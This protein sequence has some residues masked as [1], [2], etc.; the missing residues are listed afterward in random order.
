MTLCPYPSP[1]TYTL[2]LMKKLLNILAVVALLATFAAP[3]AEAQVEFL[4]YI[5]LD[6]DGPR[7]FLGVGAE[8]GFLPAA[9]LG[10]ALRPSVEYFFSGADRDDSFVQVNGD[11]IGDV[12]V[13][14]LNLFLGG[15]VGYRIAEGADVDGGLGF[16]LL[17]GTELG[18]GF[19]T[20]FVQGR[21]SI[22]D[23]GS[24][25]AA[26]LGVKLAL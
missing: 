26:M 23:W 19:V 14:P 5:G 11:L 7:F 13:G 17:A 1:L 8:F 20:P 12:A 16:N 2:T 3:R 18:T 22:G 15:G 4:P 9:P 24:A 6:I 10:V 21:V 25:L